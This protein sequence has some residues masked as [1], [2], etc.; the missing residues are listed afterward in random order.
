MF[1]ILA[2][3]LLTGGGDHAEELKRLEGTWIAVSDR[4]VDT[5]RAEAE[6]LRARL[7]RV[8]AEIALERYTERTLE[9]A[10]AIRG[11]IE[12]A[13]QESSG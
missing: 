11:E 8:N 3:L 2:A 5:M 12:S 13:L 7:A 1:T 10:E 4:P 9:E 6:Y